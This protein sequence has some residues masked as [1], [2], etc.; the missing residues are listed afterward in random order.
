MNYVHRFKIVSIKTFYKVY[1]FMAVM[2]P[3]VALWV[4]TPSV[5]YGDGVSEENPCFQ[6][7]Y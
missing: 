4:L 5:M 6:L 7:Q 3:V 2:V 1:G